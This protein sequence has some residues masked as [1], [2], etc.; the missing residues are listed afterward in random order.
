MR[1]QTHTVV[2]YL[3]LPKLACTQLLGESH[4]AGHRMIVGAGIM[5]FGVIVAKQ[6]AHLPEGFDVM[7]DLI[8]YLIHGIGSTPYVEALVMAVRKVD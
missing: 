8:G 5:V 1:I 4:S 3:N 7:G 6:A 2:E